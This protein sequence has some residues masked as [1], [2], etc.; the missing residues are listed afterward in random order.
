M[1][2]K[3]EHIIPITNGSY[4]FL[5]GFNLKNEMVYCFSDKPDIFFSHPIVLDR[6]WVILD[7]LKVAAIYFS[8]YLQSNLEF[9]GNLL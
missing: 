9:T 6:Q 1:P 3:L 2:E 7:N 4:L 8:K 5:Y